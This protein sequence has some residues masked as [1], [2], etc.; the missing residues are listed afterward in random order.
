MSRIYYIAT[1]LLLWS[2]LLLAQDARLTASASKTQVATGEQFE[3]TFSVNTNGDRFTAPSF[4]G[5]EVVS[6]PNVST[7]MTSING[8]TTV[9]NSYSYDLVAVKQGTYTIGPASVVVNGHK[10]NSNTLKITVIKGQPVQQQNTTASGGNQADETETGS[11]AS[12]ADALFIRAVTDKSNVYQGQQI[13]VSYKL[14]TRLAIS[15]S[16][17]DQL[18]QLNGFWSQDIIQPQQVQWRTEVYKGQS[19]NVADIKQTI[20]FPERSG[21]LTIDPLGMSFIVRK[22]MPARNIMEQFFG[23]TYKDVK[24]SVKSKPVTIHVK[25]LPDSGQPESFAGAVGN[26]SL[27]SAIDKKELKANEALNFTFKVSGSGNLKLLK[28]PKVDFPADFEVYDPKVT[29]NISATAN[30]LSGSRTYN[31]LVIPRHEGDFTINPVKFSYFNPSTGKYVTLSSE[32]FSIKVNKGAANTNVT[33]LSSTDQQ[34]IKVLG[35][36]IRYIKTGDAALRK[37]G[38]GFYNSAGYYLLLLLGPAAFIAALV[39]RRKQRQD[40]ADVVGVKRRRAAKMAAKHL[41]S[42]RQQLDTNNTQAFYEHVFKGLYGYLSDKLNISYAALN[43]EEIMRQLQSRQ[44]DEQLIRQLLDT[45]DLCEMA[46]Y[47]PV[48]HTAPQEVYEK[49]KDIISE[50]ENKL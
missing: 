24:Y 3:V 6:G 20:L 35:N 16:G 12:V 26:F 8:N 42:A 45:L 38:S 46:R 5:F 19:Y 48:T 18:P 21:N 47:A 14:Y 34:D 41:E 43:R 4:S 7:S 27:T 25:P 11:A 28:A 31:Y 50:I 23:G 39:Y 22:A 2:G 40:N 30:G 49:A 44:V 37:P 15:D 29:D 10:L 17:V 36:D 1:L 13:I 9:S 33:A 32:T